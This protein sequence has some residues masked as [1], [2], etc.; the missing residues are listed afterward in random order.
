MQPTTLRYGMVRAITPPGSTDSR[1]RSSKYHQGIPFCAPTRLALSPRVA[2]MVFATVG[3]EW[4]FRVRKTTPARLIALMSSVHSGRAVN[5]S[6]PL[7]TVT[8]RLCIATRCGPRAIRVTSSPLRERYA[9]SKPP[10]APAPTMAT[11]MA[12]FRI[13]GCGDRTALDL[14]RGRGWDLVDDIELAGHLVIGQ[15]R[16]RESDQL[17]LCHRLLQHHGGDH[18]LAP[19]GMRRAEGDSL[20]DGWVLHEDVVDLSWRDLLAPAVDHLFEAPNQR[21]V[22]AGVKRALI[23]GA[24]PAVDERC[25][26]GFRVVRVAVD[27]VRSPD[28]DLSNAAF[29]E[30]LA[31]VG[32]DADPHAR[33]GAHSARPAGS[34]RQR[35]GR[36]LMRGFG[37]PVGLDHRRPESRFQLGHRL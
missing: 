36:H 7:R 22:S 15:A 18:L 13:E 5:C 1:C 17:L 25:G 23:A 27:H 11:L 24:K 32:H 30:Q 33:S 29:R 8:P 2:P 10:I 26:V 9:P 3:I 28:H 14:A 34:R 21:K 37:H 31:L 20:T 35:V 6:P 19:G 16:A 4:A 12:S